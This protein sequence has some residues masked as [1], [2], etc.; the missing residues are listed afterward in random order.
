LKKRSIKLY[1]YPS[2]TP[3]LAKEQH[4]NSSGSAELKLLAQ[5]ET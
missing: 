3:L 4:A 2:I 1:S 5:V